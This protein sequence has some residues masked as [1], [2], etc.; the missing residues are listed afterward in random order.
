MKFLENELGHYYK[1]SDIFV[2]FGKISA[3]LEQI[4]D[5]Y[6]EY[7][8]FKIK[9]THS[10]LI[11]R[12]SAIPAVADAHWTDESKSA[13]LISTADCI[14]LMI[15]CKQTRRATAI[16]AGWR[17]VASQIVIKALNEIIFSGSSEKEFLFF[18]GPHILQES[19]EVLEDTFQ[20]LLAA[21]SN[22]AFHEYSFKKNGKYFVDLQKIV[23]S[24]I[25][26]AIKKEPII[27]TLKIDTKSNLNF[28][29]YRRDLK[30]SGRNL[31]FISKQ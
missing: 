24:Q 8:F 16:H 5:A 23:F 10:D 17:G 9:Q 11:V 6:P 30:K 27:L 31:S 7:K 29:S 18:L 25:Q 13:L 2:F 12:A 4:K 21:Q 22:L 15:F 20:L 1:D 14:P 19:F 3:T 26:F 28:N